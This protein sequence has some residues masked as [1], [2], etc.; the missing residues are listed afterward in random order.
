MR[1]RGNYWAGI[2]IDEVLIRESK[3]TRVLRITFRYQI[4]AVPDPSFK[5]A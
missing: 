3:P 5:T 1:N 2:F 4:P